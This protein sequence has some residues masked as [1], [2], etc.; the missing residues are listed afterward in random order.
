MVIIVTCCMILFARVQ[1][2]E[3]LL[4]IL[5]ISV[6]QA[7]HQENTRSVERIPSCSL[8]YELKTS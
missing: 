5:V 4:S 2:T 3:S 1:E 6:S 7:S 8:Q